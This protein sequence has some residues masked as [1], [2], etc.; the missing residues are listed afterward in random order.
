MIYKLFE[1]EN[2]TAVRKIIVKLS[3]L[4]LFPT[5]S[6]SLCC[7]LMTYLGDILFTKKKVKCYLSGGNEILKFVEN[8]CSDDAFRLY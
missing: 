6:Y 4:V 7:H 2:N 3:I 1:H 5:N 8:I